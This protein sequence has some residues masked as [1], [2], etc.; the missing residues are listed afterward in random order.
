MYNR[1]VIN[2]YFYISMPESKNI[3]QILTQFWGFNTFRE[4]QEEIIQSVLMQKDTLALLP[5]GGGKSICFQVPALAQPGICIVITPLIALMQDQ[6]ENLKRKGIK[7]IAI[8]SAMSSREIDIALD[9]AAYGDFKFLYVSP[10]RLETDLFKARLK[11]MKV[12]LVAVD[13]AHCISQWGYD[14]RPSYLKLAELRGE[15]P[16]IP[17]IALT[18][19]ATPKV[20]IDIQE[21]LNFKTENLI[22]KSF[23]RSNLAYVVI[24]TDNQI[25]RMLKVIDGVKGSGIIYVNSRKKTKEIA[26]SLL[27]HHIS[28]D[29]YHAGLS[30]EERKIKQS[31]WIQ[32]R[33]RIIVSTNAFGMGIDKPDVRFVI[34]LDL[35]SSLEAYFQEAGR[36][37]RDE[38]KA[39]AVLLLS[40]SMTQAL[41]EKVES[42][43]PGI[44]FIKKVYLCLANYL[45]IPVNG[46]LN[47]TY[48]LDVKELAKRYKLD[49]FATYKALHFLEKEEYIS[50]SENFA[51]PA[52]LYIPLSKEDLYKFQVSNK[53]YD[54][55][56]KT[57]LRTYGGL[58]EGFVTINEFEIAQNANLSKTK[59]IEY[60]GRLHT[61]GVIHYE[62]Q[63]SL[64]KITY[65]RAR[66]DQAQLKISKK[67]YQE[68][69]QIAFTQLTSVI[70]YANNKD[71][72]RSQLLLEY[73]GEQDSNI[74]GVCDVCLDKKKKNIDGTEFDKLQSLILNALKSKKMRLEEFNH[75]LNKYNK[76]DQVNAIQF[77]LETNR[78]SFDGIFYSIK[79]ASQ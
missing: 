15:L 59:V 44:D 30:S 10:E 41:Q 34:H 51:V 16:A 79:K 78:I 57:L 1:F 26:H 48:S 76:S 42:D 61:L 2:L 11:K 53:V 49:V 21:K 35:P 14:F 69:K 38:R 4:K 45:Q 75:L 23:S 60:L 40:P 29:Y 47:Q 9:N 20:A 65:T 77:M 28:A 25:G 19:T 50:I 71:I 72:C 58:M 31:N 7:A 43:F 62:P 22:Q 33:S 55:F 67:N 39:F 5:T 36:A 46:G 17:F 73:F 24:Q 63:S 52:R 56:I 18:A 32:N 6:V 70:R 64:P 13:E 74:C 66:T 3:H 8:H 12:N 37:G 27:E 54:N 68:R